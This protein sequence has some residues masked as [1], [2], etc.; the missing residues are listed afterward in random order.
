MADLA[1][2]ITGGYRFTGGYY[3]GNPPSTLP[4]FMNVRISDGGGTITWNHVY[5]ASSNYA[6][7][8]GVQVT[9]IFTSADGQDARKIWRV[10]MTYVG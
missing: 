7:I 8:A 10:S 4:T 2:A 1:T 3:N 5:N 9:P 6:N